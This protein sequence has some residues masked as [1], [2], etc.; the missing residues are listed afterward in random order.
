MKMEDIY[1]GTPKLMTRINLTGKEVKERL[2]TFMNN[3]EA[4]RVMRDSVIGYGNTVTIPDHCV[5]AYFKERN[6]F[7]IIATGY[8]LDLVKA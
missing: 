2:L 1:R 7:A 5:I 3:D 6:R 4:K 8:N